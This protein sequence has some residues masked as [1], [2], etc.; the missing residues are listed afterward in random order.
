MEIVVLIVAPHVKGVC[1]C[2]GLMRC[3]KR[4]SSRFPDRAM[5]CLIDVHRWP[6]HPGQYEVTR[7]LFSSVAPGGRAKCE[8]NPL[9][10]TVFRKDSLS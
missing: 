6:V 8:I 1:M 7:G 2:E 5:N 4:A 10:N 3:D 9:E